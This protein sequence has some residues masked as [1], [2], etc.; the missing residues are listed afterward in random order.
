MAEY[1]SCDILEK[2]LDKVSELIKNPD[3]V[4]AWSDSKF[5]K[6]IFSAKI[7]KSIW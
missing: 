5:E 6:E 4:N 1:E 7:T 3:D 2:K